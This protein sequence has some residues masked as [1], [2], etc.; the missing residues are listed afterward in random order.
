MSSSDD[1]VMK[2]GFGKDVIIKRLA[3]SMRI[4]VCMLKFSV[5]ASGGPA[6]CSR[7]ENRR[8]EHETRAPL[9][10]LPPADKISGHLTYCLIPSTSRY[11]ILS[12]VLKSGVIFVQ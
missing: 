11:V 2:I 6:G 4:I 8:K 12:R 9:T 1:S 10:T 7:S 5:D 3:Q